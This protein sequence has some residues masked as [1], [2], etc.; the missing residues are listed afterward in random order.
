M[1]GF[2]RQL[3]LLAFCGFGA[4]AWAQNS[5]VETRMYS[6]A[7]PAT[8]HQYRKDVNQAFEA[9]MRGDLATAM[10]LLTRATQYCDAQRNQPGRRAMSFATR[11]Q[12]ERHM[13]GPGKGQP[14]EWLDIACPSAYHQ[15][16]YVMAGAQRWDQALAMLDIAIEIAPDYPD[17][18]IER[19]FVMGQTGHPDTA[20]AEYTLALRMGE[21]SPDMAYVRPLALRGMG[22]AKTELG[23]LAG[24]RAVYQQSLV[25]DPGNQTALNELDY[26][27]KRLA[28]ATAQAPAADNRAPSP[29]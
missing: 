24:A 5:I 4:S 28:S 26:I 3:G 18:H 16:G 19:G 2:M 27:D 25:L 1:K 23:D 21:A 17:A 11:Q 10:P 12:Y 9:I 15:L 8:G 20:L 7:I 14:T 13:D 22:Y 6:Q 29:L